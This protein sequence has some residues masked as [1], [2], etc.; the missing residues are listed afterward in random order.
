MQGRACPFT[1]PTSPARPGTVRVRAPHGPTLN[2]PQLVPTVSVGLPTTS[3]LFPSLRLQATR[4]LSV[5]LKPCLA[6][7]G[8][9]NPA[10][11]QES[12]GRPGRFWAWGY[13]HPGPCTG[14]RDL[15]V[16]KQSP[17]HVVFQCL[18]YFLVSYLH[19]CWGTVGCWLCSSVDRLGG[20][21]MRRGKWTL[22]PLILPPS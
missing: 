7:E 9:V 17:Y 1:Q 2:S 8:A 12:C 6:G 5:L 20:S 22:L 14:S 16:L 18:L 13:S 11:S 21:P 10:L 15:L 19:I 3:S 4:S